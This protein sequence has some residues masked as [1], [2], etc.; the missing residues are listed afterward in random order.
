M[1]QRSC[2][3]LLLRHIRPQVASGVC[4]GHLD[5]PA[6][7]APDPAYLELSHEFFQLNPSALLL[8]SPLQRAYLLAEFMSS[9]FVDDVSNSPVL[10]ADNRWQEM[11]FGQWEGRQWQDIPQEDIDLW[12]QDLTG[13][14]P[15]EGESADQMQQRVLSAWQDWLLQQ[16]SG[17]LISHV[18]VIRMI[19]GQVL[20]LPVSAQLRLEVGYQQG[21][22]LRRIWLE[23]AGNGLVQKDSEVWQVKAINLSASELSQRLS[24]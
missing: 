24:L 15:P 1:I 20:E 7:E 19:L 3:Y 14:A 22:W 13:F 23:D 2:D 9:H 8:C 10:Q 5:L 16:K 12:Q 21:V 18:G 4:Y 17:I 11:D 6:A